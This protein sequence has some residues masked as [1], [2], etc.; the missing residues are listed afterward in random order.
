[1]VWHRVI[2][3]QHSAAFDIDIDLAHHRNARLSTLVTMLVA[4]DVCFYQS[5]LLKFRFRTVGSRANDD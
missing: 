3:A 4:V 5:R 2:S 1:M